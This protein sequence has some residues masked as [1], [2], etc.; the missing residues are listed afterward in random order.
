MIAFFRRIRQQL[1]FKNHLSRYLLYAIGEIALVMIGILLA[2]QVN[3]WNEERKQKQEEQVLLANLLKDLESA[4]QQSAVFISSEEKLVNNLVLLLGVHPKGLT[5][6]PSSLKEDNILEILWNFESNVPVI[7]SLIE[8]KN[9]GKANIISNARIREKFTSLELSLNRLNTAVKDRLT[10]QQIRIDGIAEN[11]INFVRYLNS[12]STKIEVDLKGESENNYMDLFQ[13]QNIR[14]LL[15]MKLVLSNEVLSIRQD[16]Q[17][18]L[19]QVIQLTEKE[20]EVF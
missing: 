2:L 19:D 14:N 7:N 1:I 12:P 3:N 20:L 13:K 18:E 17:N 11:E 5:F 9:T 4:A 6:S 16:L 8:I 10:V 15:V